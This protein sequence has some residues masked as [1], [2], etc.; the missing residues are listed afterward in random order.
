MSSTKNNGLSLDTTVKEVSMPS[1]GALF[2]WMEMNVLKSGSCVS[3]PTLG[4]TTG[5][6]QEAHV[7]LAAMTQLYG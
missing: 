3:A 4:H 1:K 7:R 6:G 2:S 5:S